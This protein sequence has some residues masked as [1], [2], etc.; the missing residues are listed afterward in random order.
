MTYKVG[1][2]VKKVRG[3]RNLGVTGIVVPYSECQAASNDNCTAPMHV[4]VG[5][6]WTMFSSKGSAPRPKGTVGCVR[7]PFVGQW[8]PVIP[9]GHQPCETSFPLLDDLLNKQREAGS[10]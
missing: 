10:A 3:E 4:R 8:E 2:R 7:A 1:T 6:P 9:E 5:V